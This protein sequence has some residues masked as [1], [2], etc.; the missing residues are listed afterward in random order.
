MNLLEYSCNPEVD[1]M[2]N[3]NRF[4]VCEGLLLFAFAY[5]AQGYTAPAVFCALIA[6]LLSIDG[7]SPET[8]ARLLPKILIFSIVQLIL[9]HSVSLADKVPVIGIVALC[10]TASAAVWMDRCRKEIA[11]RMRVIMTGALCFCTAALI[12]PSDVFL[13][14]QL[15]V[16]II[17]VFLPPCAGY[18]AGEMPEMHSQNYAGNNH[19]GVE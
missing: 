7:T 14:V 19:S 13:P 4:A 8:L 16:Y 3:K 12:F 2:E 15:T 11:G 9:I 18:L 10:N 6:A 17:L 1:D 5:A